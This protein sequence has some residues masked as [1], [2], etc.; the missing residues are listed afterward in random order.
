MHRETGGPRRNVPESR[1]HTIYLSLPGYIDICLRTERI[2]MNHLRGLPRR[3]AG[4]GAVSPEAEA[5]GVGARR[6][7]TLFR[8]RH[9][10]YKELISFLKPSRK[11]H[12]KFQTHQPRPQD[13]TLHLFPS[14]ITSPFQET[15][16]PT[17]SNFP[18]PEALQIFHLIQ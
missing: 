10:W 2:V 1:E 5:G 13:S 15:Y 3:S 8:Q 4:S 6:L 14:T 16:I 9:R 7:E 18:L 17:V 11:T 12:E